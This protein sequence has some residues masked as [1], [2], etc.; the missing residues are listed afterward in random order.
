MTW[1]ILPHKPSNGERE[2]YGS[3]GSR[4]PDATA[5]RR[6]GS[7]SRSAS[8]IRSLRRQ[9]EDEKKTRL[10][11]VC[12]SSIRSY[13]FNNMFFVFASLSI[14]PFRILLGVWHTGIRRYL[15]ICC[16]LG[17]R[18][19]RGGRCGMLLYYSILKTALFTTVYYCMIVHILPCRDISLLF[20][21]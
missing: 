4:F 6:N 10:S 9:R 15:T 14:F 8:P 13:F 2:Q 19:I 5:S 7:S 3:T 16:V 11:R 20:F 1:K 17:Y 18:R 12:R 21:Y